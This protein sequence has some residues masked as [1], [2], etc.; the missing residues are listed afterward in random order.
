MAFRMKIFAG[1]MGHESF[2]VRPKK[3]RAKKSR[4]RHLASSV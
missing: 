4:V 3:N 2:V 1:E